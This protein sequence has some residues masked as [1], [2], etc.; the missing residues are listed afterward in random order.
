ML[1]SIAL[2]ILLTSVPAPIK[3]VRLSSCEN[4]FHICRENVKKGIGRTCCAN[5]MGL[6]G[7]KTP[8]MC[9]FMKYLKMKQPALD[10]LKACG[11]YYPIDRAFEIF[12]T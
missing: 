6:R 1:M 11:Y 8:C 4:E 5:M 7:T 12:C 9:L 3:A 10:L 2:V